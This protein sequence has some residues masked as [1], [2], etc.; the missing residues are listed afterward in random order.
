[1]VIS[2]ESLRRK[3][4]CSTPGWESVRVSKTRG[5]DAVLVG[6]M[7]KGDERDEFGGVR[8]LNRTL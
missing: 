4:K 7:N 8:G 6:P 1:M 3:T 2:E 5:K